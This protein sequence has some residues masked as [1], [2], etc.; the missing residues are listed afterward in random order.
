MEATAA[1]IRIALRREILER[2]GEHMPH[3]GDNDTEFAIF[4]CPSEALGDAV[5]E[6]DG[7]EATVHIIGWTH[8]HFDDGSPDEIAANVVDFLADLFAGRVVVWSTRKAKSGG[9][10]WEGEENDPFVRALFD[11]CKPTR[12][13]T[14]L[15][16]WDNPGPGISPPGA[17]SPVG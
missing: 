4:K 3:L 5:V 2:L 12:T 7:A 9:W 17:G 10:F 8:G 13:G 6:V 15:G 1:E 14:W 16:P 11:V